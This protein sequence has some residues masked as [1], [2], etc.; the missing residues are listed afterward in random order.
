M[1]DFSTQ[2]YT[3]FLQQVL[4]TKYQ[5]VSLHE[6]CEGVQHHHTII[7]RHDVDR[8]PQRALTL[9]RIEHALGVNSTYYFRYKRNIF[10]PEIVTAIASLGHEIG[11]HYEVLADAGGNIDKARELFKSNIDH[12]R[13]V[14]PITTAAMH[15]RPLSPY[16]EVDFWNHASLADYNLTGEAYLSFRGASIPY[17][18]DTG[19]SWQDGVHNLRD[20]ML[21]DSSD[22]G[23][24]HASTHE[25]LAHIRTT[26]QLITEIK[27]EAHP[28]LY[29]SFH[30]ERWPEGLAA[31]TLSAF[32]DSVF[33]AIK[34]ILRGVRNASS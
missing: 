28:V 31:Q 24:Q 19:R 14:V 4:Q 27:T 22:A 1:R 8:F 5:A 13:T 10:L 20:K 12:M 2:M 17:L 34:R 21:T 30:P 26:E 32:Q 7:L 23:T 15:G 33:N 6:W 16:R 9:A 11:Y 3:H 18:N 25:K 29:L